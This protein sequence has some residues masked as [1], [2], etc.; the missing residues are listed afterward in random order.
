MRQFGSAHFCVKHYKLLL[1]PFGHVGS[2][3][4]FKVGKFD[5]ISGVEV[6]LTLLFPEMSGSSELYFLTCRSLRNRSNL[7]WWTR[8]E[9]RNGDFC[10]LLIFYEIYNRYFLVEIMVEYWISIIDPPSGF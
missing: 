7:V 5:D 10:R 8:V 4:I 2:M 1:A 9:S 6:H 3:H